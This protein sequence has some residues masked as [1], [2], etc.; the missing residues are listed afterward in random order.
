LWQSGGEFRDIAA[1]HIFLVPLLA[2]ALAPVAAPA[3]PSE[4]A[5]RAAFEATL[6]IQVQNVLEFLEETSGPAA[7]ARVHDAGTDRFEV[8]SFKKLECVREEGGHLCNFSV[9][10]SVVNGVIERTVKGRFVIGP[11]DRLT[12]IQDI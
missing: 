9:D 11:D 10:L 4:H 2:H 12:F 1:M 6:Q 7:V 5:M 3:E 8:R